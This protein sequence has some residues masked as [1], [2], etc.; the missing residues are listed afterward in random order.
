MKKENDIPVLIADLGR[1]G[2]GWL[3]YML[4]YI[5][6][7]RYIEPYDLLK[8]RDSSSEHIFSLTRGNLPGRER[9][10][11]SLVVKTHEYPAMDFNL[12]DKVICLSR[13]P[14]DVAV[15]FYN[16]QL[17]RSKKNKR[18]KDILLNCRI[19]H[20][21]QTARQWKNY[22]QCWDNRNYY[23]VKY[24]DLIT[25]PVHTL[26]GILNYLQVDGDDNLIKK[27]VEEFT[28]EKLSGRPRGKEDSSNLDFRKG[29]V[30]DYK[31][32]FNKLELFIFKIICCKQAKERGYSL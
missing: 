17:V 30:G 32:R 6:N 31:S 27:A 23:K 9:T 25:A 20:Y 13:D 19:I 11:Y 15:S 1:S 21:L 4:C 14:R 2:Q 24:E 10:K 3:S 16:M 22:Y 8:G 12:T 18:L 7:A 28:F 29:I 5:L 26:K